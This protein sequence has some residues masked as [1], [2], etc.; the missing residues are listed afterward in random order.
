MKNENEAVNTKLSGN[1]KLTN[2]LTN[3]FHQSE[4][5]NDLDND[6]R[7]E[8]VK[9][10]LKVDC[11]SYIPKFR[12]QSISSNEKASENIVVNTTPILSSPHLN[13]NPQTKS[14][15]PTYIPY[16]GGPSLNPQCKNNLYF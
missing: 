15:N 4:I 2:H 10:K 5:K 1:S 16:Q 7:Q 3:N 11:Q 12:K 9:P 6:Q 14:S 13:M 8:T